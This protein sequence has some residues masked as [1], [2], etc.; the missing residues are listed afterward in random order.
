VNTGPPSI[1]TKTIAMIVKCIYE[2]INTSI[3]PRAPF[4]RFSSLDSFRT[5]IIISI[6][7]LIPY[8]NEESFTIFIYFLREQVT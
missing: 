5:L 4:L 7:S 3:K 6:S 8:D 2:R 1:I